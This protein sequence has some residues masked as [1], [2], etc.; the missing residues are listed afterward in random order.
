M[1]IREARLEDIPAVLALHRRYQIATIAP[2]DRADGFVTTDFDAPL[3]QELIE[4]ERGLFVAMKERQAMGYVM[5][6]SW[7][8][9]AR[10]PIFRQMIRNLPSLRYRGRKLDTAN[11]YQYGPVCIAKE[12]RGSGLLEALFE[13]ARE[14]MR[15]RYEVLVT[16]VNKANPRSYA[17]HSRKL[18]LETIAEFSFGENEYYELA[19][20]TEEDL[21]RRKE[22]LSS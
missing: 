19:C 17:A 22:L 18:G 14:A 9:C 11:S 8:Y 1:I 3:L 2:E 20:L 10:W 7:D 21:K 12:H 6:A 13:Y 15:L 5:A 4:A 16:F